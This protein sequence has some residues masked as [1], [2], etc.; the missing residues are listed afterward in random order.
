MENEEQGPFSYVVGSHL[1]KSSWWDAVT[2]RAIH[3]SQSLQL[4]NPENRRL[5]YALP[6]I[7]RRK[8]ELGNDLLETDPVTNDLLKFEK[9]FYSKDGNILLFDNAGLH[10]GRLIEKGKRIVM[11]SYIESTP[12][13]RA[14]W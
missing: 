8:T 7:L 11:H 4:W 12:P 3:R 13:F 14:G 5:F 1:L 2:R 6:R 10:R 9:R